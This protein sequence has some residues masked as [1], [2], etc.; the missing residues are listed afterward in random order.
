MQYTTLIATLAALAAA[1][2]IIDPKVDHVLEAP[3]AAAPDPGSVHI[4]QVSYGGTG[5]PQGSVGYTIATDLSTVT[6]IFDSY[7]A[8]I[9]PD[10][11]VQETRSN[12]QLNFDLTYPGGFQFS[13]LSADYRGYAQLDKGVKGTMKSNYY[14]SGQ[15]KQT[16]T[17]TDFIGPMD[18]DYTKHD[19][20]DAASTVW[21]PCGAEGMLNI[22]SQVR[23]TASDKNAT[24]LLTTDSIDAKFTQKLHVTWKQCTKNSE[25]SANIDSDIM[26]SGS[27]AN[28]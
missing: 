17:T 23:L 25:T 7:L 15:S 3:Q 6:I 2:P 8:T 22:N 5:C 28:I 18:G 4:R 10:V 13:V 16:S 19:E 21:S 14:F 20:A 12:C 24:G 26:V 9:G 27:L 11:K 1:S